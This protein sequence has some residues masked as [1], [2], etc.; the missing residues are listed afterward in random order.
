M[1]A[2]GIAFAEGMAMWGQ[3]QVA[4][5]ISDASALAGGL[6]ARIPGQCLLYKLQAVAS[7]VRSL[8]V[9]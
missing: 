9:T 8:L 7:L 2:G 6:L 1:R 3:W 5:E 4:E